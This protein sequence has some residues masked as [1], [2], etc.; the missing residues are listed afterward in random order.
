[1]KKRKSPF[2][3]FMVCVLAVPTCGVLVGGLSLP[4]EL[5]DEAFLNALRPWLAVGALLGVAHVVLR[6]ILRFF[7]APL[8]CL[9]FG[10][11]GPAIDLGLL[12]LCACLI[13][14]FP[15][16]DLLYAALTVILINIVSGVA[17]ERR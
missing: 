8:G 17:R 15:T 3:V 6:P 12:Y 11:V 4:A 2:L 13:E 14:G 10:L 7:L 1:M 16:P 9:T 5:S